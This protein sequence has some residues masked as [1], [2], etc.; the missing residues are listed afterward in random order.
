MFFTGGFRYSRFSSTEVKISSLLRYAVVMM[1]SAV[2]SSADTSF[3]KWDSVSLMYQ[4]GRNINPTAATG[5]RKKFPSMAAPAA[6]TANKTNDTVHK[7]GKVFSLSVALRILCISSTSLL[8]ADFFFLCV[9]S[10][11]SSRMPLGPESSLFKILPVKSVRLMPSNKNKPMMIPIQAI[12]CIV[13][14]R[15]HL[16]P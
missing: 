2:S 11:I 9:C 5:T 12:T 1:D 8:S 4:K 10:K 13:S 6:P 7:N 3:L 14:I 16:L 15:L